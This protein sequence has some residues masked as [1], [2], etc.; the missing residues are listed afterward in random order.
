MNITEFQNKLKDLEIQGT[1]IDCKT[2]KEMT[3]SDKATG[4]VT[5]RIPAGDHVHLWFSPKKHSNRAFVQHGD[6]VGA[7][8][9]ENA[10]DK[11]TGVT[12]APSIR[13]LQRQDWDGVVKT[14]TGH[15]VEPDGFG[16]DGSPSWMLVVGII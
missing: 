13:S 14:V 15:K 11:F 7:T 16:P 2:K 9:L 4:Q 1:G 5:H 6:F 10:S 3:W 12:K 8:R